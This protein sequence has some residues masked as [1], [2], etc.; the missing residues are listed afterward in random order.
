VSGRVD[1]VEGAIAVEVEGF[2][3]AEFQALA[4][5]FEV[6]FAQVAVFPCSLVDGA[7]G[8]GWVAGDEAGFEAGSYDQVG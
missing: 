5:G 4:F 7:V 6:D 8:Y 1:E 3:A 2:V